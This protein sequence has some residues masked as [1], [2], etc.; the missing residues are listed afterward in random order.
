MRTLLVIVSIYVNFA[1]ANEVSRPDILLIM[2]DDQGYSDVGFNGNPIVKT[3]SL[4]NLAKQSLRF[5]QF[6]AQPVCSPTR[7]SLLTGMHALRTGV[8]DTQAG[9][10]V[11]KPREVT[12]AEVLSSV[13]YKT[14]IFG[15]WHLGD[16]A[17]ARPQDQG[18]DEVLTHIGGMI[19]APYS[20]LSHQSYFDP[21]LV[22]NGE[23]K[24]Y[25][26]YVTDI[27]TDAAIEFFSAKSNQPTFTFLSFNAPHHPLTVPE[28]YSQ[29]YLEQG[30]SESTA[31]YYG[32]ITNIDENIGRIL[33]VLK[34]Q[35]RLANTLI[36]FVGDNGTSSL[37]RQDDLW[38]SGLR[39]RKT[40]VYENGIR[41]PMLLI[42]PS[43]KPR[44]INDVGII[45]D[46][47]PTVL[48]MVNVKSELN[49]DGIDLYPFLLSKAHFPERTLHFQFHRGLTLELFRNTAVRKG[50]YKLVQAKGR[51]TE[52]VNT[53][54]MEF[55]LYNLDIDP[56]EKHDIADKFPDIVKLLK[57]AHQQWFNETR[58]GE[59]E[60][61]PTWI[62]SAAQN[63]VFLSRQDWIGS[64]L[65][66]GANGVY[67]LEVK[68]PGKY[69]F[70]FYWSDLLNDSHDVEI[71]LNDRKITRKLMR[72]ESSVRIDEIELEA[73]KLTLGAS[74]VINRKANGFRFIE[75]E[76]L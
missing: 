64:G 63:P 37:H 6:Y 76:H 47:M 23:E 50:P 46:L 42:L 3:P 26:G 72:S 28:K 1:L 59:F 20:A 65:Y 68:T 44:V 7:A 49:F 34:N 30:L 54:D 33:N 70:T 36:I 51:G 56:Y 69:R 66:D 57:E 38:E 40:Y 61:T 43:L 22:L 19:G 12:L 2:T 27:L 31:R 53:Q 24:K 60:F 48:S 8:T 73:G 41:V 18:F 58:G 55:E 25:K 11:L 71:L 21:M 52:L 39:G 17:P 29:S 10:S 16:N 15:K 9:V 62:G 13:G 45:E 4:D 67:Q 75:I 32:M 5:D 14:G 74:I 35:N